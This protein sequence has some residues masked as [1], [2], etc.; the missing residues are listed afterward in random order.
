MKSTAAVEATT[1]EAV[2]HRRSV[3]ADG[4]GGVMLFETGF[5]PGEGAAVSVT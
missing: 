2:D 1:T 4:A 5:G 3:V